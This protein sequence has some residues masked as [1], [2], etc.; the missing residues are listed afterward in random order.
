ME[1]PY[2]QSPSNPK[3]IW[4][5][6]LGLE[7]KILLLNKDSNR[8]CTLEMLSLNWNMT[9]FNC[10]VISPDGI[11]LKQ[12]LQIIVSLPLF[13]NT[14]VVK[15]KSVD[16]SIPTVRTF[17]EICRGSCY[18]LIVGWFDL[19]FRLLLA[20]GFGYV[21]CLRLLRTGGW[22]EEIGWVKG[23]W[24]KGTWEGRKKMMMTNGEGVTW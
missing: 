18:E 20:D 22:G 16:P 9:D 13:S 19:G 1:D 23:D 12:T 11:L 24:R 14:V 6:K 21:V 5:V 10:H 17:H 7:I 2:F 4:G 3:S 15:L 8:T